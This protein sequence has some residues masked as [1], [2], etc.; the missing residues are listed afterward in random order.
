MFPD[1]AFDRAIEAIGTLL[2]YD[3]LRHP[4]ASRFPLADTAAA[5]LAVEDGR[6]IGKT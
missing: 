6:T 1:S 5:H 3:G 2:E 4:V